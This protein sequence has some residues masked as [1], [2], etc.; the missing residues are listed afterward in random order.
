M[1]EN[2]EVEKRGRKVNRSEAECMMEADVTVKLRGAEVVKADEL[3]C[4][5]AAK[6]TGSAREVRNR[7]QAG[8][9]GWR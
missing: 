6:A 4:I 1:E 3:K 5:C 2:T 8:W 9:S 7:G